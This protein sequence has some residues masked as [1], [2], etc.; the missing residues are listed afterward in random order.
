[1][2]RLYLLPITHCGFWAYLTFSSHFGFLGQIFAPF[3]APEYDENSSHR[4]TRLPTQ[5]DLCR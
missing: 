4:R 2:G 1:M 3:M 5:P